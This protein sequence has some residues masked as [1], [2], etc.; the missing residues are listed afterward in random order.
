VLGQ[1]NRSIGIGFGDHH[2]K[3]FAHVINEVHLFIADVTALLYQI[4]YSGRVGKLLNIKGYI[5]SY[6]RE[7]Q[8]AIAGNVRERFN[9]R[10]R[11]QKFRWLDGHRSS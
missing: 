1:L 10:I 8:E 4:K 7:V 2:D 3:P 6:T 11:R 5:G 9:P